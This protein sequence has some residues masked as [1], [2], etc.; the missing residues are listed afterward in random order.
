MSK[1][2]DNEAIVVGALILVG[3]PA[4]IYLTILNSHKPNTDTSIPNATSKLFPPEYSNVSPVSVNL[5][6]YSPAIPPSV[7]GY[8]IYRRDLGII[9]TA[10]LFNKIAS[11]LSTTPQYYDSQISIGHT[12]EYYITSTNSIGE[13]A[14]SNTVRIIA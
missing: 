2:E 9:G 3:L 5:H 1:K 11:I 7:T 6:W 14:P 12:Y 13:S 8:N 4:I 10:G